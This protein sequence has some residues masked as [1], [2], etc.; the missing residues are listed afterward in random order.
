MTTYRAFPSATGPAS[1][2]SYTGPLIQGMLF[3]VTTGGCW[4]DGYWYWRADSSQGAAPSWALWQ[5]DGPAAGVLVA[6]SQVSESGGVAG[7]WNY[8]ALPVPLALSQRVP[9]KIQCGQANNFAQTLSYFA[10]GGTAPAG[11]TNGPL[12]VYSDETGTAPDVWNDFQGSFG[13]GSSN[14]ASGY[15]ATSNTAYNAWLDV[16][17]DTA[18][19]AGA[20]FCL[21]PSY[22]APIG[23]AINSQTLAYTLATQCALSQ[24]CTS[25]YVRFYS[26]PGATVLPT[27]ASIWSVTGQNRVLDNTSPSWS[28]A[29]GSGWVQCAMPGSIPAGSY[30]A[31]VYYGGGAEWFVA[32]V[33]YWTTGAGAGGIGPNG[34][35]SAPNEAGGSPGQG[36]YLTSDGYP[37]T[38]GAGEMYWVDWLVTPATSGSSPEASWGGVSGPASG[39]IMQGAARVIS[40]ASQTLSLGNEY[41]GPG[42]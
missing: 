22:P 5:G 18:A 6:N 4:L 26:P 15:A 41:V 36:S 19:P 12:F 31:S 16:L 17:I 28:G 2:Q 9:Y 40:A 24:A 7:Q 34:P 42:G 13:T 38:D 1:S 20:Q 14:P 8:V 21:F 32:Q 29:A 33:G 10:T 3:E 37:S 23:A 11:I 39:A 25:H 35:I 30:K 27:R